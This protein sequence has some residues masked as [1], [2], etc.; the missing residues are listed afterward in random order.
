MFI[1]TNRFKNK[2][3]YIFDMKKSLMIT[4]IFASLLFSITNLTTISAEACSLDVKM[5][6]QDPYPAI[7][8]DYVKIVF[9][10]EGISNSD[11]GEIEFELAE[12]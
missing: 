12:K 8:G 3:N 4:I 9:Q 7:P 2:L 5:V 1:K 11:C 10:V 6:N